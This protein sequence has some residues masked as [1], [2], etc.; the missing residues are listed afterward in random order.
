MA[1]RYNHGFDMNMEIASNEED[2]S[3]VTAEQ[4]RDILKKRLAMSDDELMTLVNNFDTKELEPGDN[5]DAEVPA[6]P[7]PAGL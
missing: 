3:D 5:V 6:A 1:H 4:I 2:A 7:A